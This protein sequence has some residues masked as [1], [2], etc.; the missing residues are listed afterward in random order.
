MNNEVKYG[1]KQELNEVIHLSKLTDNKKL[2]LVKS[3][4]SSLKATSSKDEYAVALSKLNGVDID[5]L[6]EQKSRLELIND[7]NEICNK[8]LKELDVSSS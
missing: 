5:K 2:E 3:I 8:I 4:K 6:K 7:V 1:T